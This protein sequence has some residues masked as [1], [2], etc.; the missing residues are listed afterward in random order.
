M[1][2]LI[3]IYIYTRFDPYVIKVESGFSWLCHP[4]CH[5]Y[6]VLAYMYVF[7]VFL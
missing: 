5:V 3:Y 1:N 2:W 4:F 6:I 7:C